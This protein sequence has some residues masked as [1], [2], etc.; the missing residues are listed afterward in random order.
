M[1][2]SDAAAVLDLEQWPGAKA[3]VDRCAEFLAEV[4]DL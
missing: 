1:D 3:F 2:Q 4:Q